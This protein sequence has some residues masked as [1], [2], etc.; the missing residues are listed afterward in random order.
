MS[1]C[2]LYY[3]AELCEEYVMTTKRL[4]GHTIRAELLLHLLLFA[5]QLPPVALA[6][7]IAAHLS[8]LRLLKPFPCERPLLAGWRGCGGWGQSCCAGVQRERPQCNS[9]AGRVLCSSPP[10]AHFPAT[11]HAHLQTS[12]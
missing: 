9:R 8:Y 11:L 6:A 7:G 1:A 10:P 4:I 3:L 2:G 12:S 5:D